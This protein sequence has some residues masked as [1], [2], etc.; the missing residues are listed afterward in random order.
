MRWAGLLAAVALAGCGPATV[1]RPALGQPT[2]VSLNPCSDAILAEVL[3]R[4]RLLAVS[5]YSHD[6]QGTSMDLALARTFRATGGTV[7]EVLAL[8][9]DIV[10]GSAFMP[11][12]T[13]AALAEMG[14]QVETLGIASTVAES[15]AQVR[16]LAAAV[17]EPE[18]GEALAARIGQAAAQLDQ[19]R[20]SATPATVLWQPGGIVPGEGTL[21]GE[22]MRR[23]GL[24]SHTAARGMG[25]ADYLSLE[26]VLADPPALLLVAGGERAQ[27]HP[28]LDRLPQTR[29]ELFHPS[30]LYCGGPSII[31]AAA[32]LEQ[33]R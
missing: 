21:V 31:R 1:P 8:N 12:A 13:R 11:P 23:A 27:H 32:R 4:E 16:A 28:A 3:P 29:R 22:L 7:E 17:G 24:A 19:G 6:P 14:L 33:L 9:P 10:V 18:R 30:L 5:H 15:Q 26:Q 20:A 2:V 25:Q